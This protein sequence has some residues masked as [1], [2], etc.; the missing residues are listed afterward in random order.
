MKI[1]DTSKI[2]A[3]AGY[4]GL[5]NVNGVSIGNGGNP[6][7]MQG[8]DFL[9]QANMDNANALSL[10]LAS[11]TTKATILTGCAYSAG[12]ISAGWVYYGGEIFQVPAQFPGTPPYGMPNLN[13]AINNNPTDAPGNPYTV[14]SDGSQVS[15]HYQ[16][17]ISLS[18]SSTSHMTGG[19]G[20]LPDYSYWIP[21]RIVTDEEILATI[22]A[23]VT[24]INTEITTI[25]SE[26]TT[27]DGT[28]TTIEGDI[29]TINGEITT[30]NGE[31]SSINTEIA[32]INTSV[33]ALD[34]IGTIKMFG[35][36]TEGLFD[37]SGLGLSAWLGWAL[38][39][40][41][42]G[43][44]N[45]RGKFIAGYDDSLS[46]ADYYP[47]LNSAGSYPINLSIGQLPAHSHAQIGNNGGDVPGGTTP[48]TSDSGV[49]VTLTNTGSTGSGDNIDN[50]PPYV[51]LAYVMKIS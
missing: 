27:I 37:S 5:G 9:Q 45:L 41:N 48:A 38:C 34:P 24:T 18:W 33:A 21:T 6:D 19:S 16:R 42:N 12:N 17:T 23:E 8:L 31:I 28:L 15:M 13:A 7:A 4:P 44:P 51:A 47:M 40:G 25:D 35:G 22:N 29:T 46:D 50:R 26:I 32:A 39:N 1:I 43:T 49:T 10:S 20:Y 2:S 36:D 11:D 30:I 14:L 3:Y